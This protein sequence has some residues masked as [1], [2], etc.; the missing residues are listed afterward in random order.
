[1]RKV[2]VA[3]SKGGTGKTTTAVHL[4]YGLSR[5]GRTLLIDTDHQAQCSKFLGVRPDR[6]LAE[7]LEGTCGASE[8]SVEARPN[9][10]LLAGSQ[11]LS[12][13]TRLITRQDVRA[14]EFLTEKLDPY[15]GRFDYVVIDTSPSWDALS[16]NTLFY[17][18]EVLAPI[19]LEVLSVD[20]FASFQERVE[21]IQRYKSVP[22]RHV[23]PTVLDRRAKRGVEVL[24]TL[25]QRFGEV[26][27]E[28][29][30]YSS[31]VAEAPAFGQTVFEFAPRDRGS[32]D[33]SK[34]V[35]RIVNGTT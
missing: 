26:L 21:G 1:M 14:E 3:I 18:D 22:I 5:V 27:C 33:Y 11:A 35:R 20:G 13:A 34:L 30:R 9:L 15:E 6:G 24:Q 31:R 8:A 29:I 17:S 32:E 23:L 19:S 25:Q 12:S 2:C 7:L 28:P 16:I 10:W 4:A